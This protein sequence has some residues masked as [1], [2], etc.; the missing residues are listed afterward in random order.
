MVGAERKNRTMGTHNE[1]FFCIWPFF[2]LNNLD[3]YTYCNFKLYMVTNMIVDAIFNFG[4]LK[5]TERFGI[6]KLINM[7]NWGIYLIMLGLALI[8]Y[9]YQR[10]QEGIF[11]QE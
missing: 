3:F 8:I 5:L 1:H 4:V 11:K 10:W 6:N 9:F 7:P 2:N